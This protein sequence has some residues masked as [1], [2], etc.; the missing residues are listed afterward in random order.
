MS[1]SL[2]KKKNSVK[3]EPLLLCWNLLKDKGSTP[4]AHFSN[5][6]RK[7]QMVTLTLEVLMKEV[8]QIILHLLQWLLESE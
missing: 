2:K 4:F 5:N 8:I 7:L 1:S 6:L 3:K